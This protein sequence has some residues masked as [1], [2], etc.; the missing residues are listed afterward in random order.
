MKIL[1]S[2]NNSNLIPID[3][4]IIKSQLDQKIFFKEL[5]NPGKPNQALLNAVKEYKK[6][7][8]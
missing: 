4:Q 5:M 8:D 3:L 7:F 1:K 6:L 2:L